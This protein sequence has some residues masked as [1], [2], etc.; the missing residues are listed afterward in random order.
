M[1]D[2]AVE[3]EV[4]VAVG[5]AV[6]VPSS[7]AVGVVAGVAVAVGVTVGVAPVPLSGTVW[8]PVKALSVTVRVPARLPVVLGAKV[9]PIVQF[10]PP[11]RVM[12]QALAAEKSPLAATFESRAARSRS[13]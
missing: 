4:A 7:V 3:V 9:T 11:S 1:V 10:D 6:S 13:W 8:I 2:V 12:P 5:V